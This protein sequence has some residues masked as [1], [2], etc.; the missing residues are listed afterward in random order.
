MSPDREPQ[1]PRNNGRVGTRVARMVRKIAQQ[2]LELLRHRRNSSTVDAKPYRRVRSTAI[3]TTLARDHFY[4]SRHNIKENVSCAIEMCSEQ[5]FGP[6][7]VVIKANSLSRSCN[8]EAFLA[9]LLYRR[10]LISDW[11]LPGAS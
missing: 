9:A 1:L 11:G 8:F 5:S 2:G 6:G 4:P 7:I 3:F 10:R